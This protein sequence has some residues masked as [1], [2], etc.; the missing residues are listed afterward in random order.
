MGKSQSRNYNPIPR[1]TSEG[2][3]LYRIFGDAFSSIRSKL[4]LTAYTFDRVLIVSRPL[5]NGTIFG[6]FSVD[7]TQALYINLF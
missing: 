3:K 4:D 7:F 2:P 6:K 5:R 1:D